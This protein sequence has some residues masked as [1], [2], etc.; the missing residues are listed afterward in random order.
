MTVIMR[1]QSLGKRYWRRW[2]L[3]DCTM[4]VPAGR[5]V[6]LVGPNG[7]GKSTLLSL[8]AGLLR[9]TSGTIEV[10]GRRPAGGMAEVGYVAQ[11]TPVYA[12]L[13]VADHLTL[14]AR[15]NPGWDAA[16]ASSRI[17]RLGLD[18]AQRAGTLSGG[19]RAQLALA[20]GVAKRPRLLILDEPVAALDP[21]ARAEFITGVR[22]AVTERPL[23]VVLSSHLVSD[24]ERVCDYL[25]VLVASR[26]AVAGDVGEL[27]AGGRPSSLEDLVLNHLGASA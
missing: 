4:E 1:A 24:L 2:A 3:S 20:L 22:E 14:G 25:I 5:V 10:C 11:D 18:R 13:S 26:I 6:G 8:A 19:Q 12:R 27:M 16:F 17:D 21:L 15:L 23:T 9:P 7:A